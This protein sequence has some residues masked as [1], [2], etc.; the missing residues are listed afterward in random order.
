M[1]AFPDFEGSCD[2][3]AHTGQRKTISA[4]SSCSSNYLGKSSK[5]EVFLIIGFA[6][7]ELQTGVKV[8]HLGV[9]ITF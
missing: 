1:Y 9:D 3:A 5:I 8:K 7:T 4:D 6:R 2:L